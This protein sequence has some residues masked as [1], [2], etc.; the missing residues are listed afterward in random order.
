MSKKLEMKGKTAHFTMSLKGG[1]LPENFEAFIKVQMDFST[2][3]VLDVFKVC[4]S[5]QSAR[6]A[7]QSQLR[8]KAPSE[9]KQLE[10]NGLEI[11][12]EDIYKGTVVKPIDTILAMTRDEFIETMVTQ[13]GMET[14][15]A[16]EL[17]NNKHDLPEG[18]R[19]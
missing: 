10:K 6:V 16:H 19:D 12:F 4:A 13:L 3:N 17:Y 8:Q 5:G 15:P 2:A 11:K 1:K 7:L 18:S 14:D 9:L